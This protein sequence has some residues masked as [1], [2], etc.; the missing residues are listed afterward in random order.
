MI[1]PQNRCWRDAQW[2]PKAV[3][4][5]WEQPRGRNPG[6][7]NYNKCFCS[8]GTN[9]AQHAWGCLCHLFFRETSIP[10]LLLVI[11]I[12]KC[13]RAHGIKCTELLKNLNASTALPSSCEGDPLGSARLGLGLF[14]QSSVRARLSSAG[15]GSAPP[16]APPPRPPPSRHWPQ[17][18]LP[19]AVRARGA[20][21]GASLRVA[22]RACPAPVP[23]DPA[24]P[25]RPYTHTHLPPPPV[26]PRPLA[27][28]VT[29]RAH[30]SL[31]L[32]LRRE[33]IAGQH[34]GCAPPLS[35]GSGSASLCCRHIGLWR[36]GSGRQD[37]PGGL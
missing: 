18:P 26:P 22:G 21:P 23:P 31:P 11:L 35:P 12:P 14:R 19:L 32:P 24:P 2:C 7:I 5:C 37:R 36:G 33:P 28:P 27:V 15:L 20:G 29:D 3:Q 16:S 10:C 1:Q 6:K 8:T 25:L 30:L 4:N 9:A 34:R 17:Q 13:S